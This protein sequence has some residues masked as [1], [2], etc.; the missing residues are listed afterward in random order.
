MAGACPTHQVQHPQ[1]PCHVPVAA[2][3]AVQVGGGV[4]VLGD[5]LGL[6][7]Q[8]R[9]AAEGDVVPDIA[10]VGC[11]TPA[12]ALVE[13]GSAA[14]RQIGKDLLGGQPVGV[15][16]EQSRMLGG[17]QQRRVEGRL[18]LER[19]AVKRQRVVSVAGLGLLLSVMMEALCV[20][21]QIVQLKQHL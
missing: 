4:A 1:R 11:R 20:M 15:G 12:G 7:A 10:D 21:N 14:A 13:F 18:S 8:T 6:F 3:A 9:A 17:R 16:A 2:H 5:A 19:S